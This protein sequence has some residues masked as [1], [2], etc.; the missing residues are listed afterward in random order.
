MPP[1]SK[2]RRKKPRSRE[3][4]SP[5]RIELAALELV[6]RT[7]LGGFSQRALARELGIEAMSLYHWYP[8]QLD[9]LNAMF[10]RVIARMAVPRSGSPAAR[11]RGTALSF[12]DIALRHPAFVGGFVVP[13]RFNTEIGLGV[14]ESVL[15]IFRDAGL[16]GEQAARRFRIFMHYVMG[17]VLDET[18]GYGKGPGATHPLP[19][20]VVAERYPLV[21]ALTPY[22]QPAHHEAHFRAGVDA[23]LHGLDRPA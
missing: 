13:H 15:D 5:E 14:L 12:R 10:D 16:E 9:L 22:N 3:P 7:G 18:L 21:A 4:L 17:A 20:E 1:T 11:L 8:S 6:E 23:M 19:D 2:P